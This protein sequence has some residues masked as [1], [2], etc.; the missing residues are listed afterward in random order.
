MVWILVLVA[1]GALIYAPQWWAQRVI[2]QY[3]VPRVDIPQSGSEFAQSLIRHVELEAVGVQVAAPAQDHYDP[4][5]REVRLSPSIHGG[6]SLAAVVIAAH[7]VGHA[8]QHQS[9]YWPLELRTKLVLLSAKLE[10]LGSIALIAMPILGLLTRNPR[11]SLLLGMV[12]IASMVS[13]VLVH[14]V[15]LPVELDASFKRALPYLRDVEYMREK[16]LDGAQQIL[17]AAALTYVA[18]SLATLLNVWRWLRVLRR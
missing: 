12:F 2:A 16:D 14:L 10:K 18:Q 5:T 13:S 8:M 11:V 17:L 15:T 1:V 3:S 4:R 7:E 9:G 6:R